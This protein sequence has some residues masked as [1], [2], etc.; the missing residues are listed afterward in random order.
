VNARKMFMIVSALHTLTSL[1]T[2]RKSSAVYPYT[3]AACPSVG[4]DR[5]EAPALVDPGSA[6]G[7]ANPWPAGPKEGSGYRGKPPA[8]PMAVTLG[9]LSSSEVVFLFKKKPILLL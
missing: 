3:P 5:S 8:R 9:H 7:G 4:G 2:V 1:T 6:K